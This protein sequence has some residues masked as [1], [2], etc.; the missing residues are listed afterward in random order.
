MTANNVVVAAVAA[1]KS[2]VLDERAWVKRFDDAI[3]ADCGEVGHER[4]QCDSKI[5]LPQVYSRPPP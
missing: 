4:R 5:K 2:V 1:D 3:C